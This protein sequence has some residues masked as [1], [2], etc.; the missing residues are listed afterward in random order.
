MRRTRAGGTLILLMLAAAGAPAPAMEEFNT[1]V[2]IDEI[3]ALMA[4][5]SPATIRLRGATPE[6]D[7][8]V[9][10][11]KSP[12]VFQ[13]VMN[14]VLG[15]RIAY[16]IDVRE[17]QVRDMRRLHPEPAGRFFVLA[18]DQ[19]DPAQR[20]ASELRL[21]NGLDQPVTFKLEVVR[22]GNKDPEPGLP[23]AV[24]SGVDFALRIGFPVFQAFV[25]DLEVDAEAPEPPGIC[26][27]GR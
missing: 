5:R 27:A 21:H 14:V 13:G 12:Y 9:R 2:T 8:I 6:T 10:V 24:A 15:E 22:G 17:G 1:I 25:T 20:Q 19:P 16:G 4:C 11:P 26:R 7:T 18:L 3:C 23:C